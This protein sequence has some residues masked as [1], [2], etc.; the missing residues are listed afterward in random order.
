MHMLMKLN[1]RSYILWSI[2][3]FIK[4]QNMYMDYH[5]H[6]V[7]FYI[8]SSHSKKTSWPGVRRTRRVVLGRSGEDG[9]RTG[10]G[11]VVLKFLGSRPGRGRVVLGRP[12][13]PW[14]GESKCLVQSGSKGWNSVNWTVARKWSLLS[15]P[16]RIVDNFWPC[17]F[18]RPSSRS[19]GSVNPHWSPDWD[20]IKI[21]TVHL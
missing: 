17:T 16:G 5:C 7:P 6:C 4:S 11:R 21:M 14:P 9:T 8:I 15:Q 12:T 1:K 10:R 18:C 20:L 19:S 3:L 2:W 13:E